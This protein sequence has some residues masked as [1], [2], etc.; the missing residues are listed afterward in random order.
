MKTKN[1][2]TK[3]PEAQKPTIR[4]TRD[5]ERRL[6]AKVDE[7]GETMYQ[8]SNLLLERALTDLESGLYDIVPATV[9]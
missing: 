5:N 3:Q 2:N 1:R 9:D 7:V 4:I 8:V 6:Q